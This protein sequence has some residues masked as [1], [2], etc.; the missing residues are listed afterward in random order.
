MPQAAAPS[1][2][3]S[4]RCRNRHP[5]RRRRQATGNTAPQLWRRWPQPPKWSGYRRW[6]SSKKRYRLQQRPKR[7][8]C[9]RTPSSKSCRTMSRT[10]HRLRPRLRN[11]GRTCQIPSLSVKRRLTLSPKRNR[12]TRARSQGCQAA[13]FHLGSRY[14][15][16][17][18]PTRPL[19]GRMSAGAANAAKTEARPAARPADEH[20]RPQRDHRAAVQ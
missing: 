5:R 10:C 18:A 6:I 9:R 13:T 16:R 14:A 7:T 20:A 19:S 2:S 17:H 15:H 4:E 3:A 12:S 11:G 1:S 8:R